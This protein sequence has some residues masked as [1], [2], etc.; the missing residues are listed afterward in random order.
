MRRWHLCERWWAQGYLCVYHRVPVGDDDSDEPEP[1]DPDDLPVILPERRQ[2]VVQAVPV[3]VQVPLVF[4]KPVPMVLPEAAIAFEPPPVIPFRPVLQ[5]LGFKP[6]GGIGSL[7]VLK[8]LAG[9]TF[10]AEVVKPPLVLADDPFNTARST[11]ALIDPL[12]GELNVN[13]AD[14]AR[15]V[16][17]AAAAIIVVA[18]LAR[19]VPAPIVRSVASVVGF[20]SLLPTILGTAERALIEAIEESVQ[21]TLE[22]APSEAFWFTGGTPVPDP[23][24]VG[25]GDRGAR[26]P[27]LFN[28]AAR[29]AALTE[30]ITHD[31]AF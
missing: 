2:P 16:G 10:S 14:A 18:A 4:P 5:P 13:P 25:T 7:A 12:R 6:S 22:F 30:G 11:P 3:P 31:F 1:P 24:P 9:P 15:A 19:G 21:P 17:I 28:A 26:P 27:L 23:V 29:M 8:P 20:P